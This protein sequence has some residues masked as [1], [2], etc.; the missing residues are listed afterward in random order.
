MA[1]LSLVNAVSVSDIFFTARIF[2]YDFF[3]FVNESNL[4]RVI[5]V[6]FPRKMAVFAFGGPSFRAAGMLFDRYSKRKI[7]G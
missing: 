2:A 1:F 3:F 5:T 4:Y 6:I 7:K